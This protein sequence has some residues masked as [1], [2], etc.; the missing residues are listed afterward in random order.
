MTNWSEYTGFLVGL[1]SIVN[2]IGAIPVF[3]N[4]TSAMSETDRR[5]TG[6]NAT[7]AL[8]SILIVV[9]FSGNAILRFF[10]I[11][12]SSFRVAGGILILLTGLSML[13]AQLGRTKNTEEET[14]DA[15]ERDSVAV[16]PL[17]IPLLAGPGAISSVIVYTAQGASFGHYIVIAVVIALVSL[18]SWG[19]LRSAPVI[20]ALFGRTGINVIMRI[21]GLI[22]M[23][24][25]VEFITGGLR[26]LFPMLA[27]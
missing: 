4:I 17:G 9:E 25:A 23:A 22:M 13:H 5:H 20:A 16:V 10:G 24:V 8:F 11:S 15:V 1:F 21:M 7:L 18:G 19:I 3:V 12:I 2:P 6:M 26:Q 27:G 14:Q